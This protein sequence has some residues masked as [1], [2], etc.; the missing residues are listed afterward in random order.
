MADTYTQIYLQFV[1]AVENRLSLIRPP[2][3]VELYRYIT[4]IVQGN[5]H[6][7]IAINGPPNHV[8]VLVGYEPHQLIPELL[9]QIKGGAS[10]WINDR[11]F[12]AGRFRWQA[13][14]GAF[15]YA[16]SQISDVAAYIERQEEHHR[17]RSFGKEYREMLRKADI[18]FEERDILKDVT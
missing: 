10:K 1:F 14:Y 5:K 16:R 11:R 3:K 13:G 6:K 15:S 8:H 12:T 4:G 2:W 9:Q 17:A 7:L 18:A